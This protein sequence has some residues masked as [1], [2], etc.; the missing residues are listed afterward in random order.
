MPSG[1]TA[2]T[3]LVALLGLALPG[4]AR[5]QVAPPRLIEDD[6]QE[7]PA[8]P[9]A[10][11][12]PPPAHEA[13]AVPPSV[14]E[15]APAVQ[16]PAPPAGAPIGPPA[17]RS[18]EPARK[19]VLVQTSWA[20]LVQ[21]WDTRRR[22]LHEGDPAGAD[23]AQK[24]LLSAQRELGIENLVPFAAAEVRA[25]A[26][27]LASNLPAEALSR[28]EV[29]VSLAPDWPEA[30]L[31][32]AR[33]LLSTGGAGAALGAVADA[34]A[35]AW[36]DPQSVRA[37]QGD[38]LAALGAALAAA[39]L[40]T[41]LLPA[42]ARLRLFLHDFHHLPL[43][44]GA[45]RA[46][47]ALVALALLAAPAAL[48]LGPLAV[49][50]ALSLCTWLYL[51]LRERLMASAAL[52][53]LFLLPWAAERAVR[54]V[55]WT[56]TPAERV[57][58]IE[59]GALSDEE[60]A[61]YLKGL[62][63]SPSEPLLAAL[64]CH[65]KRRGDLDGALRLYRAAE[66][67]DPHAAEVLVN[68]G[69]VLFLKDDLD[70]ARA[71]YLAAQDRAEGD[72]VVRGTAAY[73]LSKLFVRTAEM[74]KSSAARANA[75]QMA[76]A[77]LAGRGSDEDFSAN[78]Y[79]VDVPVPAAK[80]AAL[81][82]GDPAPAALRAWL[83]G[84]LLRSA[85]GAVWPW[86]ATGVLAALW[87]LSL[88]GPGLDPSHSCFRC[89]RPVCRRCDA[90]TGRSCGQC[91]NV[92]ERRGVV[93]VRDQLRKERQVRR[94][95]FWARRIARALALLLGGGGHLLADA[96]LRGALIVGALAFCAFLVWFWPG[97]A[98][99]P[100]PSSLALAAKILVAAPLGLVIW[101]LAVRDLFRRTGG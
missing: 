91:V 67:A 80:V 2:A 52:A 72:L 5:P 86:A 25:V 73:D 43:V 30:H 7:E 17:S 100:N 90:A 12:T 50:A 62:G 1:T 19:V 93:E 26:R 97:V 48:G 81:A 65:L 27:A 49:I 60:A 71:A 69:N 9:P 51:S 39:S 98:P 40:L 82:A 46:Q 18:P 70:G 63:E 58:R 94:H 83:E 78:R 20:K 22:A 47:A 87:L 76:G 68:V 34:A 23:A 35:A 66:T 84:L 44:R 64:G 55:I 96:P 41:L 85:A 32:R 88:V 74:E 29:A 14:H 16:A 95:A 89:G 36:R 57:Y 77:F 13:V 59:H 45:P 33:A 31:V 24:T 4:L 61:A 101:A 11:A 21:A 42:L 54:L 10:P 92:F 8:P 6:D 38:L 15:P 37:L 99:P 53:V 75:E 79:L 3:A 56:G 28:A